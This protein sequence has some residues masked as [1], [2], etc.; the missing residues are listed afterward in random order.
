MS[1]QRYSSLLGMLGQQ[2]TKR[3]VFVSFHHGNDRRWF[4][5]FTKLFSETYDVFYDQ[6]VDGSIRSNDAEYVDRRIREE[7]ITG[8]SVTVVLCGSE[9]WKRKYVDW[10]IYS[11]LHCEHGLLGI[12][13]PTVSRNGQAAVVPERLH[14]NIQSGFGHFINWNTDPNFIKQE[15]ERAFT[16]SRDI[17][18]IKNS[19][20]KMQ[21][22][23]A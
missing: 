17:S 20:P 14:Q 19:E 4:D 18:K 2:T 21:R 15:I 9:T 13:L 22:N 6:S 11:T 16:M 23:K 8:S 3:K 1:N 10:E 12:A 5:E 7:F